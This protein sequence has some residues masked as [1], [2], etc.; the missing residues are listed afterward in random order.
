MKVNSLYTK[1]FLSFLGILI[2][3]EALIFVLFVHFAG[4]QYRE[5]FGQHVRAQVAFARELVEEKIRSEP[6]RP[7][8]ENPLLKDLIRAMGKSYGARLWLT[9][10]D[11]VALA[12][13]FEGSVP[14]DVE[15]G[16]PGG[17]KREMGPIILYGERGRGHRLHVLIPVALDE[18]RTG[19]LHALFQPPESTSHKGGFAMGLGVIGGVIALL[20][21]P[22]SRR[23]TRPLNVLRASAL[24]IS[25]GDLSHRA[26]VTGN[27]EIGQ[28]GQAFNRMAEHL[29]RMIR[30]GKELMAHVSHALRSPLARIRVAEEMVRE[31][32]EGSDLERVKRHLEVI[33]ED[34]EEL[35]GLIGRILEFSRMDMQERAYERVALDLPALLR[36]LLERFEPM[37]S[38]KGL[39]LHADLPP[40]AVFSG[41]RTS[42]QSALSNLLDNAVKFTPEGGEICVSVDEEPPFLRMRMTNTYR[43]LSEGERDRLFDPFYRIEDVREAGTGLGLAITRKIV[44][45]NGGHLQVANSERGLQFDLRLPR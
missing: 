14:G 37:L 13:S 28:L 17:P 6:L 2:V 45:G 5:R 1:V 29:E 27:D 18:R 3:T 4:R 32:L 44:E 43:R 42:L 34:V 38:R 19:T 8:S 30:G 39:I 40:H 16:F 24:R 12:Q 11:G 20:V 10:P 15:E 31:H 36:D 21:V 35:D 23:I 25:E 41:D 26:A 9:D 33:C 7:P 22:V